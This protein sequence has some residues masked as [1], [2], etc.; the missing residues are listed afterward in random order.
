M[1]LKHVGSSIASLPVSTRS[2]Q[3]HRCG[4]KF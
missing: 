1:D 3:V 4:S 2:V